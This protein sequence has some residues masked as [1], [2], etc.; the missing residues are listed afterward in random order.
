VTFLRKVKTLS[1]CDESMTHIDG[2][3]GLLK[4][5]PPWERAHFYRSALAQADALIGR[6]QRTVYSISPTGLAKSLTRSDTC[7]RHVPL[8]GSVTCAV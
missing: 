6:R 3:K 8:T 2:S 1:Y 7:N 4:E 5:S